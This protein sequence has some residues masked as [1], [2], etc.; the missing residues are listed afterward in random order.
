M[1]TRRVL[2]VKGFAEAVFR[3]VAGGG[4]ESVCRFGLTSMWR[5]LGVKVF[6]EVV[7]VNEARAGKVGGAC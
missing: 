1:L 3:Q 5:V 2:T 7:Y 6:A 4:G